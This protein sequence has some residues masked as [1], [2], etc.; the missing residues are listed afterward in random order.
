MAAA[1]CTPCV[2]RCPASREGNDA[3]CVV[4]FLLRSRLKTR[5]HF[6][7]HGACR[8]TAGRRRSTT[9]T[10]TEVPSCERPS[11]ATA[12]LGPDGIGPLPWPERAAGP[13]HRGR[14]SHTRPSGPPAHPSPPALSAH[15]PC[16]DRGAAGTAGTAAARPVG[17][18]P[19]RNGYSP[20]RHPPSRYR[21][22]PDP[23]PPRTQRARARP[24][25]ALSRPPDTPT[26]GR[27]GAREH[28]PPHSRRAGGSGPRTGCFGRPGPYRRRP[29][30]SGRA[31]PIWS[32]PRTSGMMR[33]RARGDHVIGRR[34]KR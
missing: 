8:Q 7:T 1:P 28:G 2:W 3:Q 32:T 29:A 4:V 17:R 24:R 14:C 9:R 12:P 25:R 6:P 31:K 23:L 27:R 22:P 33:R 10:V 15:T 26:P 18:Y 34:E 11:A 21:P 19:A 30:G 13:W 5:K 20:V 16:P